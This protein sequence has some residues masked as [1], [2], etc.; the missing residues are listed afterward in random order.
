V[1][2]IVVDDLRNELGYTNKNPH[3]ISPNIDALAAA[4]TVFDRAY[5]QQGV[6]SPSRNSF[7]S[8][9]RPDTTKIWNFKRSFRATLPGA[10]SFPEAFKRNGWMTSGIGKVYHPGSPPNHDF[11]RSWSP[12]WPYYAPEGYATKTSYLADSRFQDGMSADMGVTRIS[13]FR[14]KMQA[15]VA[16]GSTP[17]PFFLAVGLHKPH[18]PWVMPKR[19]LDMQASINET[20]T[21]V[22][23]T[24][25]S[26]GCDVSLYECKDVGNVNPFRPFAKAVQQDKRRQYRAA[27][28]WTDFNV[29]RLLEALDANGFTNDTLVL[30]H[31]DH[32]WLLGEHGGYCKQSNFELVARVPLVVKAPWLPG[33]HGVRSRALVEIVDLFPTALELMGIH[34]ADYVADVAELEGTSFAPLLT[35]PGTNSAQLATGVG[36]KNATFTQYP[37]CKSTDNGTPPNTASWNSPTDNPC[38]QVES[39][40]FEAMGYSIRSDRWRYTLWVKWDGSA[41]APIWDQVV[42]E[43]LYDHQGDDGRDT[44]AFENVNLLDDAH[45]DVRAQMK[46]SLMVG[47]R[48][49]KPAGI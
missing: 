17:R 36:W 49:S 4:G 29:G 39:D 30:F 9:R 5:V 33:T 24:A 38:T 27:T 37:R 28:T 3:I 32:G 46:A 8:G 41:L 25:P 11:P 43:E 20:D 14:A 7:L 19:F 16:A 23:D 2:Y 40:K 34:S 47:W 15:D 31:G 44:D 1:L 48:A 18:T 22:H 26:G 12:E 21:A 42:G 35:S 13:E 45:A 10:T 6:C